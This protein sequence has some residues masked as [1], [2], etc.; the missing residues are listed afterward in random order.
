MAKR[1]NVDNGHAHSK[2]C[3]RL[4]VCAQSARMRMRTRSVPICGDD[5]NGINWKTG[6]TGGMS[7]ARYIQRTFEIR[8]C[9]RFDGGRFTGVRRGLPLADR[10]AHLAVSQGNR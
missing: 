3:V 1:L 6:S 4:Y 2:I 7:G 5:F 9:H 8:P 10:F